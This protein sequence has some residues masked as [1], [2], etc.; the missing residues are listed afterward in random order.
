MLSPAFIKTSPKRFSYSLDDLDQRASGEVEVVDYSAGNLTA[1]TGSI[2]IDDYSLITNLAAAT[3]SI[4]ITDYASMNEAAATGTITISAYLTMKLTAATGTITITDY[5]EL[6]GVSFTIGGNTYTEGIHFVAAGDNGTTATNLAA[7]IDIDAEFGAAAVAAAI[8]ITAATGGVAGNS[9]GISTDAL[10][11]VTL[12]G[13]TLAGGY[14]NASLVVDGVTYIAGT[15]F[16]VETSNDVTATNLAAAIDTDAQGAA[17]ITNVVTV[18][19]ATAGTAGNAIDMSAASETGFALSGATL[20]GGLDYA[21]ITVDGVTYVAGTDFT[22]ETND[23]TTATNLAAAIDAGAQGA[24]AVTDTVTITAATAGSAGNSIDTTGTGSGFTIGGATLTGG[25]DGDT[26]TVDGNVLVAGTDFTAA[27]DNATTAESL[28]DAVHALGT[29]NATR[30]NGVVNIVAATAGAAGNSITLAASSL[31]GLSLSGATLSGGMAGFVLT[32]DGTTLTE[33]TDWDSE[34]DNDTTAANIAASVIANC[35]GFTATSDGAVV[36]IFWATPGTA[37]NAKT[38]VTSDA[39]NLPVGGATLENGVAASYSDVFDYSDFS[40][41][42]IEVIQ[43]L[44]AFAGTNPTLDTTPQYSFDQTVWKDLAAFTQ[45][46]AAGSETK[47]LSTTGLYMRF[48][49]VLG[50]TNP[51]PTGDIFAAAK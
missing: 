35:A 1:A 6:A 46:T 48:K 4:H 34:T 29:V 50:G 15:D 20:T 23:D 42:E 9:I 12:S 33:G 13:A 25:T 49:L 7:V 36:T 19:A 16:T 18:T 32:V 40:Q 14:D 3:Q 37:G 41:T 26:V 21:E 17:A 2:T 11:G 27:T 30:T 39:T 24:G 38:L 22:A 31:L 43:Q 8:T 51:L 10:A 45:L 28:K 5:T 44:T 47:D